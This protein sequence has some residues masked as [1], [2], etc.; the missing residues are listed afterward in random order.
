MSHRLIDLHPRW[1]M[2]GPNSDGQIWKRGIAFRC[3]KCGRSHQIEFRPVI[4]PV[5]I[6][7]DSAEAMDRIP[8]FG[9]QPVWKR[10]TE[11][12]DFDW[13][14]IAPSIRQGD[15]DWTIHNGELIG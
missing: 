15:C 12:E 9:G 11:A 4:G 8:A 5:P 10:T 2:F 13:L 6:R 3:P 1:L 14:C 7:A